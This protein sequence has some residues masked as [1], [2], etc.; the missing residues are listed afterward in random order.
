MDLKINRMWIQLVQ[1]K[2]QWQALV[3]MVID[4]RSP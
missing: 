3:A 4:S 2:D 1:D